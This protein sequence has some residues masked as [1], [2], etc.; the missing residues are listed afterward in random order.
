MSE[1]QSEMKYE[2]LS[3]PWFAALHAIIWEKS[4]NA[5]SSDANLRYSICEVFTDVPSSLATLPGGR[6]AWHAIVR[7][8]DVVFG[9]SERDDVDLKA[10]ADYSA[11]LPLARFDTR[12]QA[13]RAAELQA[14]SQALATRGLLKVAG[15]PPM[16]GPFASLHDA[17]AA[18]T[19]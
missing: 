8:S 10:T 12:G 5:S 16:N 7:G 9:L 18:L 11:V 13:D 3:R 17:I 4:R 15:A 6:V 14:M 1:K 19:S 2:F